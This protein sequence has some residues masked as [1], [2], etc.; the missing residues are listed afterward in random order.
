M[1]GFSGNWPHDIDSRLYDFEIFGYFFISTTATLTVTKHKRI[2]DIFANQG[3]FI[4]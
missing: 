1:R 4:L 3:F 2:P